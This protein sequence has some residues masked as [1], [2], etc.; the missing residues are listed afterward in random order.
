MTKISISG[1]APK[2]DE[3]V[4]KL[5]Q[6]SRHNAYQQTHECTMFVHAE[7]PVQFL[8]KVIDYHTKGFTLSVKYPV[9]V[10]AG[11]YSCRMEKPESIQTAD[12]IALAA[13]VKLDYIA[14]LESE[15]ERYKQLLTAQLLQASELKEAEKIEKAKAK[16]LADIQ[17]EV[18]ATFSHLVIPE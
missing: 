12:K 5:R 14:W 18:D 17:K 13:Q 9:S 4:L 16:L 1:T 15:H 3:A 8:S 10:G 6:E 7:I 11:S 2:Y